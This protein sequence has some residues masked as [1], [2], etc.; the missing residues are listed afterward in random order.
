M[1]DVDKKHTEATNGHTERAADANASS[2]G[3]RVDDASVRTIEIS[4]GGKR[5]F[6]MLA[7][8]WEY[9][10]LLYLLVW[11]DIK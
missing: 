9:R 5:G 2:T 6:S 10:E 11:R 4:A 1:I 3:R 7:E 8:F